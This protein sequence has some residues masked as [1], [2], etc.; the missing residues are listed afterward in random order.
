MTDTAPKLAFESK[1]EFRQVC[2]SLSARLGYLNRVAM[3][4]SRFVIEMHNLLSEV[5]R[6]FDEHLKD[7]DTAAAF[8]DG[9]TAG[10]I[11]RDE[12]SKALFDLLYPSK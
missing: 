6:V 9:Y 12:Q 7:P 4:E 1:E 2:Q 11:P 10:T 8:G 5:G 3:G